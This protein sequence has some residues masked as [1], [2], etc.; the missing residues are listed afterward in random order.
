MV[1]LKSGPLQRLLKSLP[2]HCRAVLVYGPDAG[3][4]AERAGAL[5]SHFASQDKG[6]SDVVRLDDRDLAEDPGRLEVELRTVSM[7]ADR[8]VVR[9]AAGARLDVGSLKA[10]LEAPLEGALVVEA[11]ALRPDSG[12]R[13]LFEAHSTAVAAP[14][15]PEE[16]FVSDLIDEEL[17]RARLGIDAETKAYLTARL[18]ADQALSRAEVVKLALFAAGR[19]R[20][21]QDDID[22]IVGDSAEIAVENFVYEVSGGAAKAALRQLQRLA[23]AGTEPSLA[24]TALGRHFT[25]LHRV[26]AAQAG[27]G[28]VEQA[29][30]SLR[31]PPHYK[32]KDAFIA[33]CRRLGPSRLL[34]A[35]P[36]IQ[37]AVKR[38]RLTPELERDFAERLV[39]ALTRRREGRGGA[40]LA[41]DDA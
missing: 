6:T 22:A 2:P 4:V 36:V 32:R 26:A 8:K 15:Y 20:I 38:S 12:L 9:I 28:N 11:G 23:A 39:L 21:T 25:Q 40:A 17:G 16:R 37:E 1:A 5:G 14:C 33:H 34:A 27:G 19:G 31:P 30:R 24:L 29:M 10:L 13:K 7:F 18:G 3:L 41:E 35:L